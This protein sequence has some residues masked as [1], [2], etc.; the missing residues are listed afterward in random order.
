MTTEEQKHF[1]AIVEKTV[2]KAVK[3]IT[4]KQEAGGHEMDQKEIDGL[5]EKL[6]TE[7]AAASDI[8][9]IQKSIDEQSVEWKEKAEAF[10]ALE[11]SNKEL[12]AANEI[13]KKERDE[14]AKKF[15]D[16]EMNTKTLGIEGVI[17]DFL[18]TDGVQK[19]TD[20]EGENHSKKYTSKDINFGVSIQGNGDVVQP[21]KVGPTVT[22]VPEKAYDIRDTMVPIGS[23]QDSVT[24]TKEL[25][26]TDGVA[27][28]AE[29]TASTETNITLEEV[30]ENSKRI[31]T[32][33]TVSRTA[34]KNASFLQGYLTQR[35]TSKLSDKLTDQSFNGDGAGNNL[36]GLLTAAVTFTPGSFATLGANPVTSPDLAGLLTVAKARL[37]EVNNVVAN[38]AFVNPN[39]A[40]S[41]ML[42]KNTQND[43]LNLEV[44]V[45][46]DQNGVVRVNGMPLVQTHFIASDKYLVADLSGLT[47]QLLVVEGFSMRLTTEHGTDAIENQVTFVFESRWIL[48]IYADFRM[49][50]GTISTDITA[51]TAA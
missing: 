30:T 34:L 3:V 27:M 38:I 20:G 51:I 24:F 39:N 41:L 31:A 6:K 7:F 9:K 1:D 10:K 29:N 18:G 45:T 23:S 48:P 50:T 32:H 33:T 43:Y 47:A 28:L 11:D 15:Q 46:R 16:G 26:Y 21:L 49:I 5:K 8:V 13:A 36:T 22:F 37:L 19:I 35:I 4:D 44:L 40:V 12:K 25:L 2:E 14:L 17:K 42:T